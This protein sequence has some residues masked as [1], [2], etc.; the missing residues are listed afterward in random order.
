MM[1]LTELIFA[2]S[3]PAKIRF[4]L[5]GMTRRRLYGINQGM[6]GTVRNPRWPHLTNV[7]EIG[8]RIASSARIAAEGAQG[9]GKAARVR[10]TGST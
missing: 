9:C 2:R 6:P 3:S 7:M 8:R 1:A 5:Y 10:A 4:K